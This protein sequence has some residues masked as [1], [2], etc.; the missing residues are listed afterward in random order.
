MNEEKM[1]FELT[2]NGRRRTVYVHP[3][4]T[5][6]EADGTMPEDFI[7]RFGTTATAASAPSWWTA[8]P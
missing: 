6:L 3:S 2:V 5:L 7:G 1:R 8:R 4:K